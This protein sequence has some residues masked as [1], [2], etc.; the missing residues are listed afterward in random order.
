M[1]KRDGIAKEA[2]GVEVGTMLPTGLEPT[3]IWHWRRKSR[4]RSGDPGLCGTAIGN[5]GRQKQGQKSAEQSV[6]H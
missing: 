5:V 3:C 2:Q 4:A 1:G 6:S